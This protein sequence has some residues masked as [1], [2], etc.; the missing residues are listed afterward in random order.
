M[1]ALLRAL[2]ATALVALFIIAAS[3]SAGRAAPERSLAFVRLNGGDFALL[4]GRTGDAVTIWQAPGRVNT[5][6]R[7]FADGCRLHVVR[8]GTDGAA[9]IGFYLNAPQQ[10][11]LLRLETALAQMTLDIT[12]GA[13]DAALVLG[14]DDDRQRLTIEHSADAREVIRERRERDLD[15][16]ANFAPP[17]VLAG[18]GRIAWFAGRLTVYDA[19]TLDPLWE[20]DFGHGELLEY[21]PGSAHLYIVQYRDEPG[22]PDEQQTTRVLLADLER[23]LVRELATLPD[24]PRRVRQVEVTP[25]YLWLGA[26]PG[27]DGYD[28]HGATVI[29]RASGQT[30]RVPIQYS[31]TAPR[32]ITFETPAMWLSDGHTMLLY[33]GSQ[34][35]LA[36]ALT[37]SIRTLTREHGVPQGYVLGGLH[38][39]AAF[40]MAERGGFGELTLVRATIENDTVTTYPLA[41]VADSGI[42]WCQPE[43]RP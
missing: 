34:M 28:P 27:N 42:T 23:R 16:F 12:R 10:Q 41:T 3:I 2:L 22:T 40:I 38:D 14:V 7:R 8:P 29:Q 30:W 32:S 5:V 11:P 31:L 6:A 24:V 33:D 25:D 36:D 35:H 18:A 17:L 19:A 15:P 20:H 1:L 26:L 21:L 39:G 43:A 4:D 13:D 9:F 37:R